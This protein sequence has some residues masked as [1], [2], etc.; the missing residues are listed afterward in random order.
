MSKPP[1]SEGRFTHLP[2]RRCVGIMLLNRRDE[3]FVGRRIDTTVEAWQM[4]QGGIDGDE[5][6]RRA[7]LR[8]MKEEIGTDHAEILAESAGWL[9]YDLPERLVPVV[10][11]GR[12]R[13]QTMKWFALRFLGRDS[14]IDIA[15]EHAEFM[16]WRWMRPDDLLTAIVPFKHAVYAA[17]LDEFADLLR[18]GTR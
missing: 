9:N 13:G 10:W 15:T 2:Y 4:P 8:E 7:A 14:D 5:A 6:P 16:A 11:R 12:Y 17:V 3:V 1:P 18:P